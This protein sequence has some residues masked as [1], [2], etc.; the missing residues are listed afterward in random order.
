MLLRATTSQA[1]PKQYVLDITARWMDPD[2]DGD[3]QRRNRW[4]A[5]GRSA[6]RA[7]EILDAVE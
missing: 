5:F 2:R 6:R 4:L 3:P 7:G 1:G